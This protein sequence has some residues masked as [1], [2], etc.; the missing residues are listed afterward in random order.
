MAAD[1]PPQRKPH[2]A[3][4]STVVQTLLD[5]LDQGPAFAIVTP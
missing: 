5:V 2:R 1:A 3:V 4:S